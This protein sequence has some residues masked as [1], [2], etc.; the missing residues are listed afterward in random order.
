[1]AVA[2]A[3]L[4]LRCRDQTT[5]VAFSTKNTYLGD[6]SVTVRYRINSENPI[7]KVWRS[8]MD[9]HAAFAPNHWASLRRGRRGVEGPRSDIHRLAG[10]VIVKRIT[11]FAAGGLYVLVRQRGAQFALSIRAT[12]A[13][14]VAFALA[15]LLNLPSLWAVLTAVIVTQMRSD[16]R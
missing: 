5:E 14:L 6:Q 8:S 3:A 11:D 10:T 12:I 9:G 13:A 4:I 1:M 15:Q 7:K 2:D 16:G